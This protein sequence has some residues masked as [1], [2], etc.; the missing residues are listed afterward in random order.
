LATA[1]VVG[2]SSDVDIAVDAAAMEA[3]VLRDIAN[4]HDPAYH[5]TVDRVIAR[6]GFGYEFKV[7]LPSRTRVVCV[8]PR[9]LEMRA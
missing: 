1:D 2:D 8:R 4:G 9:K 5:F 3:D 6:T 7:C